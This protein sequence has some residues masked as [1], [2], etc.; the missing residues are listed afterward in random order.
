M[1]LTILSDIADNTFGIK[2]TK[3][4]IK[5]IIN[6]PRSG[7]QLFCKSPIQAVSIKSWACLG[8]C[9]RTNRVV[10]V[11]VTLRNT[12]HSHESKEDVRIG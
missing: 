9:V 10:S 8:Y 7:V 2:K 11:D 1:I 5:E 4:H 12:S 3:T 6:H